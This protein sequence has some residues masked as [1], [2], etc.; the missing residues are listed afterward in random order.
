MPPRVKCVA[1]Y[2]NGRL[3]LLQAKED[4]Y[5]NVLL[6]DN[7]GKVCEAPTATFFLI[8]DSKLITPPVTDSILESITR[9]IVI[10]L[11]HRLGY[12][13]IE[14]SVDRTELYLA[15]GLFFAG[16][17]AEILPVG[18]IDRFSVNTLSSEIY[19]DIHRGYFSIAHAD[20]SG[21]ENF[22]HLTSL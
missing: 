12:N 1:N 10:R 22:Y 8:R 2:Q 16:T 4:G 20:Y 9:D 17:G 18:S 19:H 13:V 3:A 5:D 21:F 11:A 14:R 6:V 7:R 15:Q